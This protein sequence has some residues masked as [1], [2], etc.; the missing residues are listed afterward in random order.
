MLFAA[1]TDHR[2]IGGGHTLDFTNKAL[3]ALDLVGWNE[4]ELV[5]SVL[6]SLVSGYA[7]AELMEESISWRYPIDLV[8]ILE[9]AFKELPNILEKGRAK[10]DSSLK[11][12]RSDRAYK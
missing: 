12:N 2:F 8:A 11:D 9:S 6:S 1:A 7:D 5:T 3:E 10:K 4:K